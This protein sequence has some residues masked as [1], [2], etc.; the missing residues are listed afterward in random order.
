M[1][2]PFIADV[3]TLL[4]R[5]HA[6]IIDLWGVIHDGVILHEGVEEV[7]SHMRDSAKPYIFLSNTSMVAEQVSEF[8]SDM[9]LHETLHRGHILT[10]G[11]SAQI[12]LLDR[13]DRRGYLLK[14]K[15]HDDLTSI[16]G[17]RVTNDIGEADYIINSIGWTFAYD[18][19]PIFVAMEEGLARNLPMI[20]SNPDLEV[21]VGGQIGRCA[22]FYAQIYEDK[23]GKV[24]WHGKP[25]LP[26]Y[27]NAA[28]RLGHPLK[29]HILAIGDSLRT[30]ISGA[31]N[32]G[33]ASLWNLEGT[34]AALNETEAQKMLLQ[35]QLSPVGII[36]GLHF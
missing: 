33:I 9:G 24:S 36:K 17:I 27:E 14:P 8:L 11:D 21:S 25:Y 5:Y 16:D 28:A 19:A 22:G 20:C 35:K 7:L 2:T 13:G 23:G 18:E 34:T 3:R 32:F 15:D 10:A 31:K 26:I 12:A 4:G 6:Y 1:S 29:D 30:D